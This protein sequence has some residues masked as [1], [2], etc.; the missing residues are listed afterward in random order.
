MITVFI[1][2]YR[3]MS[4]AWGHA[5]MEIC[6][7]EPAGNVYIS[8]WPE[9]TDRRAKISNKGPLANIYT[10]NAIKDRMY[11]HDVRDEERV[12]DHTIRLDGLDESAAKKYWYEL[13]GGKDPQWTSL[14][15]NCSTVVARALFA[16]GGDS[17]AEG[18]EGW[19]HSWNVIWK[20][21][22]VLSYA[23]AVQTGLQRAASTTNQ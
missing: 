8:W 11:P 5:S 19:W 2:N 10:V 20:P 23:R 16:A 7:G 18:L 3:G 22:D 6:G 1:W 12:P 21:D 9:S 4:E 14:T 13:T 17:F 15:Q